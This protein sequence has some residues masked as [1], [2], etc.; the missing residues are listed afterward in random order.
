LEWFGCLQRRQV[1]MAE[2]RMCKVEAGQDM[3]TPFL[4][5]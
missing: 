2:Q 1:R 3:V 5:A 4:C